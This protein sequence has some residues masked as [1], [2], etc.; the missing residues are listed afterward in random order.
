MSENERWHVNLFMAVIGVSM[1]N[2]VF[3][4]LLFEGLTRLKYRHS[5]RLRRIKNDQIFLQGNFFYWFS[6]VAVLLGM[7]SVFIA[8]ILLVVSFSLP[9]TLL[10]FVMFF[11]SWKN[12]MKGQGLKRFKYMGIHFLISAGLVFTIAQLEVFDFKKLDELRAEVNPYVE[13]PNFEYSEM[14]LNNRGFYD[15]LKIQ[16][17]EDG[18]LR[19]AMSRAQSIE[20]DSIPAKL[21]EMAYSDE[22]WYGR[23]L[24]IWA[25]SDL[26]MEH[27][28]TLEDA[29]AKTELQS[30]NFV[31][32]TST[33][34]DYTDLYSLSKNIRKSRLLRSS[35]FLRRDIPTPIPLNYEEIYHDLANNSLTVNLK[36]GQL[37]VNGSS[38]SNSQLRTAFGQ[39]I[40]QKKIV[41]FTFDE[42][43]TFGHYLKA[44]AQFKRVVWQL[45]AQ[46][47]DFMDYPPERTWLYFDRNERKQ[48]DEVKEKYPMRFIDNYLSD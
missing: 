16:Q 6:R 9:M 20:L 30:V 35:E 46:E 45:R 37:T 21:N 28:V 42:S 2:S 41:V 27:I 22:F 48:Y 24:D 39:A 43:T 7:A 19:Y 10:F 8:D 36:D 3:I 38:Y 29:L 34:S 4:L 1:A 33:N 32:E 47:L 14:R 18:S 26:S 23:S 15:P 31:I 25:P 11:E 17:L 5:T 44:V 12:I 40:Q 13:L